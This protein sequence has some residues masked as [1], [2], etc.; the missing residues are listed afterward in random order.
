MSTFK[1]TDEP[2]EKLRYVIDKIKADVIDNDYEKVIHKKES[3][4]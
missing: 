3:F 1:D 2:V 4:I